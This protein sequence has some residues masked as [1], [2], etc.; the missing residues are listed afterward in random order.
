MLYTATKKDCRTHVFWN[1]PTR[2]G[3]DIILEQVELF[4][5]CHYIIFHVLLNVLLR[6]L[7][8]S[9]RTRSLT[10]FIP[11]YIYDYN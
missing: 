5:M 8:F 1:R 6:S 7:F 3:L 11:I 9:K 10:F 4:L 2:L